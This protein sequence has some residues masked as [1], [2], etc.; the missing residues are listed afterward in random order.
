MAQIKEQEVGEVEDYFAKIGVAA[1][2]LTGNLKVGD[3]I[4][5]HGNTTDFEA[6]VDSIQ[7]EHQPVQSAKSGES[8]GIK[9]PQKCRKHDRVAVITLS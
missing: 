1:V 3:R 9:V 4:H 8:V 7:I 6:T 5:I 2:R